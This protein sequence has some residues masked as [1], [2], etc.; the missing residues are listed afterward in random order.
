MDGY[1]HILNT[2]S[3]LT[4][5]TGEHRTALAWAFSAYN[6][7][8]AAF[9]LTLAARVKRG[10][11]LTAAVTLWLAVALA[12]VLM[13]TVYPQPA[14]EDIL[15]EDGTGH[16]LLAMVAAFGLI[17]SAFCWSRAF[18]ADAAWADLAL[19]SFVFGWAI[20][21]VGGLG[22]LLGTLI[23]ALF[24]L[25]ERFTMVTYLGWFCWIAVAAMRKRVA[26]TP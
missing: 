8:L 12:G 1:S 23:P 17:A 25:G 13:V 21:G 20:L 10:R 2:V 26:P 4:S 24:G 6:V 15:I 11:A 19:P 16:M 7:A 9:G 18:R 14:W 3:E 5:T 22:A